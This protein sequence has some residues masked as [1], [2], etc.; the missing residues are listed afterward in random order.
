MRMQ[1]A[2]SSEKQG[3]NDAHLKNT[4]LHGFIINLNCISCNLHRQYMMNVTTYMHNTFQ[5]Y[6]VQWLGYGNSHVAAWGVTAEIN[7]MQAHA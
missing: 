1:K 3:Y 4:A 7:Q 6:Y 2:Q 5:S